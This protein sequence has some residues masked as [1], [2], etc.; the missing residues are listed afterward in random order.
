MR[1]SSA[2]SAAINGAISGLLTALQNLGSGRKK[3]ESKACLL[4]GTL[5]PH[6]TN[7]EPSKHRGWNVARPLRPTNVSRLADRSDRS[8]HRLFVRR[9]VLSF[10]VR[11]QLGHR[12]RRGHMGR[13][14]HIRPAA[15]NQRLLGR[16]HRWVT[17]QWLGELS[18]L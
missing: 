3:K 9:Q 12:G 16:G 2:A 4:S 1:P 7:E 18:R 15:F 6:K 5:R 8:P 17:L 10:F 13:R 14:G 11:G